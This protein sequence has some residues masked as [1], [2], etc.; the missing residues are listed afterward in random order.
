MTSQA[1]IITA[2]TLTGSG[3]GVSLGQANKVGTLGASASTADFLLGDAIPLT[4]GGKVAAGTGN[5]LTIAADQIG[6]G[7]GGTLVAPGG[8]VALQPFT[9]G[10]SIT[11]GGGTSIGTSPAVTATT[12]VIGSTGTGA[13]NVTGAVNLTGA[14]TLDLLS[15]GTIAESGSGA[16]A[17][18]V[19]TGSGAAIILDGANQ[20][21]TVTTLASAGVLALTDTVPLTIT[22]PMS[23]TAITL[24]DQGSI[25]APG[26]LTAGT[27]SGFAEG[28]ASFTG[29][30]TIG[31]LG[32]FASVGGFTLADGSALT[33]TGPVSDTV[34]IGIQTASGLALA[35]TLMAP[36]VSLVAANGITQSAGIV[37]TG[38]LTGS[39]ASATLSQA[40]S[41]AT[42]GSFTSPGAVALTDAMSL[43]ITGPVQA[44]SLVIT[45]AGSITQSAALPPLR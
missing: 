36:S 4:I 45:D 20:I 12:L 7:T 28:T 31:T 13:V 17:A 11:I 38:T 37:S 29:T 2:T 14:Q 19:L 34:S 26:V 42:L 43:A 16:I 3:A 22:G 10:G 32:Q 1:G 15:S 23:G 21:A 35:G 9:A 30:N 44:G 41:I 25:A 5:T 24:I 27:L 8:T 40:N 6:F 33:V 39:A 18:G